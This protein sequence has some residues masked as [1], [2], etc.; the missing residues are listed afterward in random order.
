MENSEIKN[1]LQTKIIYPSY[2]VINLLTITVVVFGNS[3][4]VGGKIYF[5]CFFAMGLIHICIY[6]L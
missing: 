6:I 4:Y 3:E 2:K 5:T 1:V